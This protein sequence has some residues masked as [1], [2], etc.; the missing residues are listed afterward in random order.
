SPGSARSRRAA[1]AAG[2]SVRHEHHARETPV[3]T[4]QIPAAVPTFQQLVKVGLPDDLLNF[5]RFSELRD[6]AVALGVHVRTDVVRHL[7]RRVAQT[8]ALI[9]RRRAEPDRSTVPELVPAPEPYVMSL[10][11]AVTDR[12]LKR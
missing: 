2:G 10:T 11:G 6:D 3:R 4:P 9:E 12:L 7:P 5:A 1:G 8:D